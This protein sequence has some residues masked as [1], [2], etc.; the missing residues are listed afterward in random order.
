LRNEERFIAQAGRVAGM[1]EKIKG[2]PEVA[3]ADKQAHQTGEL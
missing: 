3:S 1:M 2:K